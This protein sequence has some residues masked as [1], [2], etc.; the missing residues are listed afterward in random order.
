MFKIKKLKILVI[1]E[2]DVQWSTEISFLDNITA[3]I[4]KNTLGKSTI[5]NSI[6]YVLGLEEL[7]GYRGSKALKPALTESI[8]DDFQN[9]YNVKFSKVYLEIENQD[10]E[11]IE[12]S[13]IGKGKN[14]EETNIIFTKTKD[15]NY[16]KYYLKRGSAIHEKGFYYFLENFLKIKLP[17]V[18]S[19][20][21]K[22]IKLYLQNIFSEF[23]IEQIGGWSDFLACIPKY[24]KIKNPKQ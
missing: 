14:N 16:K 7:L 21:N 17:E 11:K 12:L 10:L 13:R 20:D 1:D 8:K 19:Y 4:G 24:Y 22:K 3:I 23:F 18:L 5:I 15:G 2:T 6:Y 9:K